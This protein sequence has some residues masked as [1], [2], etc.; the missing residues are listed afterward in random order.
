MD[1]LIILAVLLGIGYFFGT[2]VE[3][4]HFRS[5]QQREQAIQGLML[6]TA[7]AKVLL[8]QA[9]QA[10]LFVGS[11]VV[12]SD[13]FKTFIAGI[14]NLLGGRITVYESLLE[15]GRREAL[16]RM[17]ESAQAWGADQ[18][19]NIRIQAAELSGNSGKGVVALEVMAYGTGVR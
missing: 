3:K 17:E 15:R 16:L 1:G 11:V 2:R 12:S 7:G 19:V 14:M 9:H 18:V 10:Q 8:P 13:F 5:L 4:Q 6:S